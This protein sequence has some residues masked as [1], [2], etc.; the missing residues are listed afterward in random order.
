MT[1]LQPYVQSFSLPTDDMID[2]ANEKFSYS[3]S[4]FS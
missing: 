2:V 4:T 3:L 1:I